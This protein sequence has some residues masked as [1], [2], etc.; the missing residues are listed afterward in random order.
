MPIIDTLEF[1]SVYIQSGNVAHV[2]GN[3]YAV[4][5]YNGWLK[6]FTVAP[7]GTFG[8]IIATYRFDN[9]L[10]SYEKIIRRAGN[11]FIIAYQTGLAPWTSFPGRV[12]TTI[13]NNDGTLGGAIIDSLIIG[14]PAGL[15]A[16]A[17][18][19]F[20]RYII[21][22]V[23]AVGYSDADS[24]GR[25]CTI[26]IAADGTIGAAIIDEWEFEPVRGFPQNLIFIAGQVWALIYNRLVS[27]GT[28][29]TFTINGAGVIGAQ[30]D[31]YEFTI[32]APYLYV[33][34]HV[35]GTI[36]GIAYIDLTGNDFGVVFTI[37]INNAGV[38][39]AIIDI[40]NFEIAADHTNLHML[41][42]AFA[43]NRL[44]LAY[45]EFDVGIPGFQFQGTIV[46]ITDAGT[47]DVVI[48]EGWTLPLD[49]DMIYQLINIVGDID[50]LLYRR[51]DLGIGYGMLASMR[52]GILVVQ[53]L[54]AIGVT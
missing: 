19:G 29:L 10:C 28:I 49:M 20:L 31:N 50:L 54:A 1:E 4:V 30:I 11:V 45:R 48:P 27:R 8:A 43:N 35:L 9:V 5:Y 15:N 18:I 7:D 22:N 6:T 24:D 46:N 40:Q 23:V 34:F 52:I 51:F 42:G 33:S 47:I 13:I 16:R 21:G 14:W 12:I 26:D 25:I 32:N 41:S 53:T 17:D 44:A 3:V 39:G 37:T 38:I 36:Y 2:S